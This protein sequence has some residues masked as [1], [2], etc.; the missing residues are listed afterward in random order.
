MGDLDLEEMEHENLIN[1]MLS[2]Y[3]ESVFETNFGDLSI[4]HQ[5]ICIK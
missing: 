2:A 4:A 5:F 1:K 3:D